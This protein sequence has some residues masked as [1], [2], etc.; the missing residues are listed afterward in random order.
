MKEFKITN[1]V[2]NADL[3]YKI[4]IVK[5]SEDQIAQKDDSFPGAVHQMKHPVKAVL[6]FSS[7][8][9]VFT[10]AKERKQSAFF[11]HLMHLLPCLY[12]EMLQTCTYK[13]FNKFFCFS[14]LEQWW[15]CPEPLVTFKTTSRCATSI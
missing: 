7:G 10:G 12:V 9:V 4:D 5:L 15:L 13:R 8:K 2:A 14:L 3:G 1:I 6:L 11:C